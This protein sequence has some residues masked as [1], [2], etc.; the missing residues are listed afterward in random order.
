MRKLCITSAIYR[1]PSLLLHSC[2]AWYCL[3]WTT[4]TLCSWSPQQ[5][6]FRS[7]NAYRTLQLGSFFSAKTD[8]LL[9]TPQAIALAAGSSANRVQAAWPFLPT[10][11]AVLRHRPTSAVTSNPGKIRDISVLR[12]SS[13]CRNRPPGLISPTAPSAAPHLP[14]GTLWTATLQTVARLLCLSRYSRLAYSV[15]LL[16]RL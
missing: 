3:G 5:A 7:Y 8:A 6:V 11:C 9:T 16:S 15:R 2:A 12:H 13:Y 1:R 10:K 14:S 4:A